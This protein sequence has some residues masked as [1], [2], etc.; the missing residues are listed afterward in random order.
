MLSPEQYLVMNIYAAETEKVLDSYTE[1]LSQGNFYHSYSYRPQ[2]K[3]CAAFFRVGSSHFNE[4]NQETHPHTPTGQPEAGN[5]SWRCSFQ[6][7]PRLYQ[8]DKA[9]TEGY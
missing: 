9:T 6:V 5:P 1:K 3:E 7:L 4:S 2:T 8:V